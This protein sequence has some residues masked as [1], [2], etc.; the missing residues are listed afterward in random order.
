MAIYRQ[1]CPDQSLIAGAGAKGTV[2]LRLLPNSSF[3]ASLW[4]PVRLRF[5]VIP[6]RQRSP[7]YV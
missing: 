7:S 5:F 6:R 2:R 1:L 3:K 4:P